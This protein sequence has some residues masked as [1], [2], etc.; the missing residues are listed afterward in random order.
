MPSSIPNKTENI[1]PILLFMPKYV[2]IVERKL[3]LKLDCLIGTAA[4]VG[5]AVLV[6]S[7]LY[8]PLYKE[9]VTAWHKIYR[10]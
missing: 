4:T 10:K 3:L 2:P 9:F 6:Q 5:L 1:N 8:D 7:K